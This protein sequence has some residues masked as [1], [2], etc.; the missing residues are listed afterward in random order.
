MGKLDLTA[1]IPARVQGAGPFP[2]LLSSLL[3]MARSGGLDA[4]LVTHG[5]FYSSDYTNPIMFLGD[6]WKAQKADSYCGHIVTAEHLEG[7]QCG[8]MNEAGS[9]PGQPWLWLWLW[10]YT[11]WYPVPL[12]NNSSNGDVEVI[13]IM[14]VCS[15][16]LLLL[17][18]IPGLRSIPRWVPLHRVIWRQY[19]RSQPRES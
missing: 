8:V 4:A 18:F 2:E 16:G 9:W 11:M 14:A 3:G 1:S 15:L 12:M 5:S 7:S 13:A 19:Y 17:P 6:S 10:L